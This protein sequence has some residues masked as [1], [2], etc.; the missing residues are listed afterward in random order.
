MNV[1][2]STTPRNLLSALTLAAGCILHSASC[3]SQSAGLLSV[4]PV[5]ND[6]APMRIETLDTGMLS[7]EPERS[8]TPGS[9]IGAQ[10]DT[11]RV[12]PYALESVPADAQPIAESAIGE[13]M[14]V[15]ARTAS[16]DAG[17]NRYAAPIVSTRVD[18]ASA[19]F[20][21]F[22]V[23]PV[24]NSADLLPGVFLTGPGYR[25]DEGVRVRDYYGQFVLRSDV[26]EL[27]AEGATLLKLRVRELEAVR[28]LDEISSSEVFGG[29]VVRGVKKPM[30]AVRQVVTDPVDT[31]VGIPRG[32][33]R[34]IVRTARNVRD[35]AYD[36]GDGTRDAMADNDEV[37]GARKDRRTR[38]EKAQKMT[39]SAT[40]QYLGY[41]KARRQIAR[42]VGADPYS[43]NPL[44]SER[45]D[46][47]AWA[48]WTGGKITS[49]GLGMIGGVASDAL[50]YAKDAYELVWELPPDDLK[51]RN[52][53]VLNDLGFKGK[54]ARD[55]IRSKAFTLTQQTEFVD[56]LRLPQFAAGREPLFRL[57]LKAEREIHARFL[58]VSLRLLQSSDDF[59]RADATVVGLAPALRRNDGSLL[60]ALPVDYLHWTQE[61]ADFAWREDLIGQRNLLLTTGQLSPAARDAFSQ[62][63]WMVQEGIGIDA[64]TSVS[65]DTASLRSAPIITPTQMK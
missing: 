52:L 54:P 25:I 15:P 24:L 1:T 29:A 18:S 23:A 4:D 47:L 65:V 36:I 51:R 8:R 40:L 19:E 22:E 28:K 34:L 42:D 33:G 59:G 12:D 37:S 3:A 5:P 39:T 2:V 6:P 16:I 32:V 48:S 63:G 62:A 64:A 53:L 44:L 14:S 35:V 56:L 21:A 13:P 46:R 60:V 20:G 55:L 10:P 31:L 26:G 50:G 9:T 58:I 7:V 27:T 17:V 41:N 38:G 30:N 57:A 11:R 61:V 45:L 43:T 49:L